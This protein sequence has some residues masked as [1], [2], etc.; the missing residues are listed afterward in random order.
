MG[1]VVA[2]ANQ[3]GGVGKTTISIQF[4]FYTAIKLKKKVLVID[5]DGQGNTSSRLG[6][7]TTDQ[8]GEEFVYFTG[9]KSSDLYKSDLEKIEVTKCPSGVDLIH[10]PVDDT[11]LYDMEAVDI[12]LTL[13][14]AKNLKEFI[15][16]YDYVIV[17][18]PPS[19]G[20]NLVAALSFAT[21]V[22]SPIKFS[23][24]AVDGV[25]RLM[26]T[27]LAIQRRSNPNLSVVGLIVN[28]LDRSLNQARSLAELEADIGDLLFRNKIRH[29]PPL[30]VANSLGI[31]VWELPYGH[32][33]AKEVLA[34]FEEIIEK[35]N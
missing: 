35:I 18:C 9:T 13:N 8:N 24:F 1:K 3:K 11:S 26:H 4:A 14:P 15:K 17:D 25:G 7:K 20:R 31:P 5:M 27:L 6:P 10:V 12:S 34:V 16:T 22:I 19:L 28:D 21:H 2:I 23:C 30:D 29:R 32:V 33:A